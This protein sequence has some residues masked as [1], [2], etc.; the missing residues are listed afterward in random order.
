MVR[1]WLVENRPHLQSMNVETVT[2]RP[3]SIDT[4]RTPFYPKNRKSGT[5]CYAALIEIHPTR[6]DGSPEITGMGEVGLENVFGNPTFSSSTNRL[7]H[8]KGR[9]TRTCG[10]VGSFCTDL[11]THVLGPSLQSWP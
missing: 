5:G 2:T 3:S 10:Y 4:G 1:T 8:A 6:M 9:G 7:K 11:E